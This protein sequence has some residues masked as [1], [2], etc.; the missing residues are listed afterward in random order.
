MAD[1]ETAA[2]A[3]EAQ[4]AET[5]EPEAPKEEDKKVPDFLTNAY[6]ALQ[7]EKEKLEAEVAPLRDEAAKKRSDAST[8]VEIVEKAELNIKAITEL[9]ESMERV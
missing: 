4:E 2:A 7:A 5:P 6:D 9:Q 1:E 3:E 8:A